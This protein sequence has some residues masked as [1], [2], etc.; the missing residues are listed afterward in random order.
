M[1]FE[2]NNKKEKLNIINHGID[3][4]TA[5]RVFADK[6]CIELYDEVHSEFEDRY[7]R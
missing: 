7:N 4:S 5:A 6:N 2:W 1:T 3:F